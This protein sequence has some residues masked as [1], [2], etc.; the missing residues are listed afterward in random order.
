VDPNL[1]WESTK[2]LNVGIDL[3][4]FEDRFN[5]SIDYYNR[6]NEGLLTYVPLPLSSGIGGPFDTQGSILKNTAS[7]SNKGLEVTASYQTNIGGLKVNVAGN[8]SYNR[9]NVTSL[10]EGS[11]FAR[12]SVNGGNLATYTDKGHP[13]GSFF[14]YVVDHVAANQAEVDALNN[15]AK[16]LTGKADVTYQGNFLPGDIVF[17]DINNDGI[18]DAHDITYLGSPIPKWNYGANV[19]IGYRNFDFTLGL[20]GIGDVKIWN[21][22]T[23]WLEGTS[24]P[25]NSLATLENRWKKEGDISAF[26]KAGQN[27]NGS[28]NLRPSTRFVENGAFL[29]VRNVTF[30]YTIPNSAFKNKISKFRVYATAQNLF[31]FTKYKG[32]DPEIGAQ[33]PDDS[34]SFLFARGIDGGNYP[35]PRTYMLG[36]QL[37]F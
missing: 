19:N 29:R 1:R 17:K 33:N 11:P 12:G 25:F 7:A 24:R 16:E 35:Q 14:G 32:Y 10:G 3:G 22:M 6:R 13:I 23:Y 26:P 34:Q 27:A 8:V 30:G 21:D 37:A 36:V 15:K 20:N 28:G 9:N 2:Q 5:L 18:I 4:M 31:T